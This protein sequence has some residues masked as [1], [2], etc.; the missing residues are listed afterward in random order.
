MYRLCRGYLFTPDFCEVKAI[1]ILMYIFA[2]LMIAGGAVIIYQRLKS[3]SSVDINAGR[4]LARPIAAV[5]NRV[6]SV[7]DNE[8]TC[9][10]CGELLNVNADFCSGCG[11]EI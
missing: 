10:K 1:R 8:F 4:K 5:I 9:A 6:S 7:S 11:I 3:L 2:G